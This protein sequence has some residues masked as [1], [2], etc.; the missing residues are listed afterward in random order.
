MREFIKGD[1]D[2]VVL[3]TKYSNA[4]PGNNPNAAGNHRKSMMQALEA[5]LKRLQT[6]NIDL[7]WL[8]LRDRITQWKKSC[9]TWTIPA[10]HPFYQRPR[11]PK[12]GCSSGRRP[13]GQWYLRSEAEI[14]RSLMDANRDVISPSS[15]NSQFSLP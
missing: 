4:A 13:S 10:E 6:V 7:Y 5:S 12:P 2:S 8:H 14:G 1:R 9:A 15:L 11:S 3:S